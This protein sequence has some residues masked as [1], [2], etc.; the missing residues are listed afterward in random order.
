[1]PLFSCD[2]D[3][4]DFISALGDNSPSI[5]CQCAKASA[6][7]GAFNWYNLFPWKL[8]LL[9]LLWFISWVILV[10]QIY[11]KIA[12]DRQQR[13]A[14]AEANAQSGVWS[15]ASREKQEDVMP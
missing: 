11:K 3:F 7:F 5:A 1:L 12:A 13:T 10:Y 8:I 6:A 4:L 2:A 15:G 14:A 9:R